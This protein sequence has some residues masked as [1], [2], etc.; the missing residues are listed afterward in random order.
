MTPQELQESLAARA[1]GANEDVQYVDVREEG[2]HRLSALPH[3][4]LL[5]LSK[6]VGGGGGA[7]EL[8]SCRL[9]LAAAG[10]PTASYHGAAGCCRHAQALMLR[11]LLRCLAA[12][13]SMIGRPRCTRCWTR[14]RR[15]WFF[16]TT[17]C[18]GACT[19]CSL[20]PSW[21]AWVPFVAS[22]IALCWCPHTHAVPQHAGGALAAAAGL[23]ECSQRHGRHRCVLAR[24]PLGADV[25]SSTACWFTVMTCKDE[26]GQQS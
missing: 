18:G 1:A 21:P 7:L 15:P 20:L 11:G 12:A 25:L 16:A 4:Q 2:E 5:P 17:A 3:F 13:G 14:T 24:G 26:A 10:M 23:H 9:Q 8:F 22:R 6:Y 19:C